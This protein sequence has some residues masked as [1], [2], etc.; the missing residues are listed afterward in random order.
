MSIYYP[1]TNACASSQSAYNCN[2][3]PETEFSRI[4]SAAF[5]KKTYLSTLLLSASSSSAWTTACNGGNAIVLWECN[6]SY[7]GGST[8]EITGFGDTATMPGN[9]THT[10]VIKDRNYVENC[11]FWNDIRQ[12][13]SEWTFVYRTSSQIHFSIAE[14]SINGRNPVADD[15]NAPLVWEATI[16]WTYPD[17]PCPYTTPTG[18]FDSCYINS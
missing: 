2:P 18:V 10:A 4:R 1:S 13:T 9:T 3:C 17:S 8:S 16:K 11:D 14:V 15:L 5:V 6:G 12:N 7:D